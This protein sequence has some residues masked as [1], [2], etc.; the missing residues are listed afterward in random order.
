[1]SLCFQKV[2]KKHTFEFSS[3]AHASLE[4]AMIITQL[5]VKVFVTQHTSN[6]GFDIL[7]ALGVLRLFRGNAI[8]IKINM[9]YGS[10]CL[11]KFMA[12]CLLD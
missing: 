5:N 7:R 10:L 9:V 1:M 6:N 8:V 4:S 2:G 12:I 3:R 11:A